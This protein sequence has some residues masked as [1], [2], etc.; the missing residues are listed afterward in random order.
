MVDSR[1]MKEV[2][3]NRI[4][5]ERASIL[6][7]YSLPLGFISKHVSRLGMALPAAL[8]AQTLIL[9]GV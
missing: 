9:P 5:Y 7:S 8:G 1:S 2:R 4:S 3:S 6:L